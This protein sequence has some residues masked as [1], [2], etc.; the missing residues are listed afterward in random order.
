MSGVAVVILAAGAGRRLGG[1]CKALLT[2]PDGATFLETIARTAEA[3]GA[4]D[5]V[6]VIGDPH[7]Q[8]TAAEAARL[9]LAWA[10]N[11]DPSRGMASS[12]EA[13]FAYAA[14]QFGE[15]HAALL[16]PVDHPAV[17]AST[18]QTLVDASEADIIGIPVF[19]DRG[20]HPTAFGRSV[21]EQLQ[22]CARNPDGARTV[23][24]NNESRIRRFVVADAGVVRDV[25]TPAD[26]G[27]G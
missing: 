16:W 12:I 26:R 7:R 6:V 1:V 13:G 22:Q 14:E 19:E 20:G 25:D 21:W 23:L 3:A 5:R 27:S 8:Q 4:A 2:R 9:G 17:Q 18:V 24:R 10:L 15:S 11:P